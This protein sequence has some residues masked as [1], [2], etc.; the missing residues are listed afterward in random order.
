MISILSL[1]NCIEIYKCTNFG[2]KKHFQLIANECANII[3]INF[4]KIILTPEFIQ[5]L[6]SIKLNFLP[7]AINEL[8]NMSFIINYFLLKLKANLKN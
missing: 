8:T 3:L 6:N 2:E 5:L 7:K 1:E 4:S